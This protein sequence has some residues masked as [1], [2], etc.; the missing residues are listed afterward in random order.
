MEVASKGYQISPI[1]SCESQMVTLP[2]RE[3]V[4]EEL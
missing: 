1:A 4:D 3:N 2:R